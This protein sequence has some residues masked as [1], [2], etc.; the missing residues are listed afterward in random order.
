[1]KISINENYFRGGANGFWRGQLEALRLIREGGFDTVDIGMHSMGKAEDETDHSTWIQQRRE[2]C[3][4]IGLTVNQ[5]HAPFCEGRPIF[6]GFIERVIQCVEDCSVL[7]AKCLVV[8]GDTWF[9]RDYEQWDY[10]EVVST[11]YDVYAPIVERAEKLGIKIAFETLFEW[12]GNDNHR[13][14]LCSYVEEIDDLIG[15]FNTDTV[16]VC[17]DFGHAFMAYGDKQFEAMKRLNGKVI[18]THVHDNTRRYDNHNIPYQ[19]NINWDEALKTLTEIGY[20]GD[21]T[22]EMNYG[23]LPPSLTIDYIK[24]LHSVGTYMATVFETYRNK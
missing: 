16:G 1:M 22:F 3:D 11:V 23:A 5:A 6:D 15:K 2:F 8:H 7:G 14:R 20:N 21:L 17:W 10:N 24:Y 13:V 12:I 4:K 19:G 18:A 9:K